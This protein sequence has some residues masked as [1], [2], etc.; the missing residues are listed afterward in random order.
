[1]DYILFMARNL[2][3]LWPHGICL[4]PCDFK[5]TAFSPLVW[6]HKLIHYHYQLRHAQAFHWIRVLE[7]AFFPCSNHLNPALLWV[8]YSSLNPAFIH[9]I[10]SSHI[11]FLRPDD[12]PLIL[13]HVVRMAHDLPTPGHHLQ[14]DHGHLLPLPCPDHHGRPEGN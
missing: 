9:V 13:D 11:H 12:E 8:C 3:F 5:R 4:R 14:P 2:Q 1:M 6:L 10:N 7:L